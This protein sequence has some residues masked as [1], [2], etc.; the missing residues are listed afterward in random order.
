MG[1]ESGKGGKWVVGSD[2]ISSESP[3]EEDV[4]CSCM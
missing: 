1:N 3:A 2:E 4:H